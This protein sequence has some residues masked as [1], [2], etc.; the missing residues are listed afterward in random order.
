[1][2]GECGKHDYQLKMV[3]NAIYIIKPHPNVMNIM[4]LR[5]AQ[6][7][8]CLRPNLSIYSLRISIRNPLIPHKRGITNSARYMF[9]GIVILSLSSANTIIMSRAK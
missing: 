7:P 9:E 6:N 3:A 8:L 4:P 2:D 5:I 1:M